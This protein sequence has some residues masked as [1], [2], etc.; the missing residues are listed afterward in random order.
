[1]SS[2]FHA[3]NNLATNTVKAEY[4]TKI[5]GLF[6]EN[7]FTHQTARQ[8][9]SDEAFKSLMGSIKSGQKIDRAMAAQIANGIRAWAETKGVKVTHWFN[10][11]PT[12]LLFPVVVYGPL[13]R[14]GATPPGIL[15]PRLLSW[16]SAMEKRF[17]SLRSLFLIPG[18]HWIIKRRF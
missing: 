17:A 12:L 5:T 6:A 18:N 10:K 14:Q 1:M 3:L 2:R 13:L 16:I 9:L 7:V 11:N 15:P 8:F 4:S